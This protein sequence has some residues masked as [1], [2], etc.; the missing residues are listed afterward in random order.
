MKE[1]AKAT[2]RDLSETDISNMP[3]TE[4]K[5]MSIRIL[6]ELEKRVEDVN[7]TLNTEIRNNI[8]EIKD[9]MNKM[10][11]TLDGMNSSME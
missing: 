5:T 8:A 3:D 10:R 1:Q 11:N 4:F 9:T 6:T 2:V 7:E